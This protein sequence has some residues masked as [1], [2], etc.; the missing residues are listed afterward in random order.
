M[1]FPEFCWYTV[2][3]KPCTLRNTH[4]LFGPQCY[5]HEHKNLTCTVGLLIADRQVLPEQL[6]QNKII[7]SHHHQ[8]CTNSWCQI[9]RAIKFCAAVCN[10]CASSVQNLV[11]VTLLAPGILKWLLDFWKKLWTPNHHLPRWITTV[12]YKGQFTAITLCDTPWG[13]EVRV[14]RKKVDVFHILGRQHSAFKLLH[15]SICTASSWLRV[16]KAYKFIFALRPR[17]S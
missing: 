15:G 4:Y 2:V 9:T 1:A 8:G 16:D 17:L 3:S 13:F 5:S 10:I 7:C 14:L 6:L 12:K 11:Y